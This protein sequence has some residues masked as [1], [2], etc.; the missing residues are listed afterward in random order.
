MTSQLIVDHYCN[1]GLEEIPFQSGYSLL[2][3]LQDVAKN[4]TVRSCNPIKNKLLAAH[5]FLHFFS[6]ILSSSFT[7][8]H[9]QN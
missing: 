8:D 4:K 9:F 2:T 6:I 5:T 1:I 3:L 7:C